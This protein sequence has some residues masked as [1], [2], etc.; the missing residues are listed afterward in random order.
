MRPVAPTFARSQRGLKR[1][2][3]LERKM[4]LGKD[5]EM[6][7]LL[8]FKEPKIAQVLTK[9]FED[10]NENFA[11]FY[12]FMKKL[13]E[14]PDVVFKP[15]LTMKLAKELMDKFKCTKCKKKRRN[16]CCTSH[17]PTFPVFFVV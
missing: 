17:V 13:I 3:K 6:A 7:K 2:D 11:A 1:K 14:E 15:N 4:L 5:V 9:K 8:G 10:H 12:N 16:A